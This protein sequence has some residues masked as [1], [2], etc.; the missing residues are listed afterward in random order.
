MDVV[1]FYDKLSSTAHENK[2]AKPV[3]SHLSMIQRVEQPDLDFERVSNVES[4]RS[5][6]VY[7]LGIDKQQILLRGE[8]DVREVVLDMA[9]QA[10]PSIRNYS[11]LLC[12]QLFDN[13]E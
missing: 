2:E 7:K 5:E 10:R 11:P 6:P 4:L 12:Q 8:A 3:P 13:S 9:K 1:P